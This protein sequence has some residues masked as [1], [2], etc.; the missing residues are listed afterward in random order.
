MM[1]KSSVELLLTP[2]ESDMMDFTES[3]VKEVP[4]AIATTVANSAKPPAHSAAQSLVK[5]GKCKLSKD[6]D[7]RVLQAKIEELQQ[8]VQDFHN[9]HTCHERE[10]E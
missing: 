6:P 9:K 5:T 7:V 8:T 4:G 2:H 10:R 1:A 3:G